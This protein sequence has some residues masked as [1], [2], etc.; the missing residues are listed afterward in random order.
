MSPNSCTAATPASPPTACWSCLARWIWIS[1]L[2]CAPA[3]STWRHMVCACASS[4]PVGHAARVLQSGARRGADA[5]LERSAPRPWWHRPHTRRPR[6]VRH[7]NARRANGPADYD[8]EDASYRGDPTGDRG[9]GETV[10]VAGDSHD[11]APGRWGGLDD[12]IDLA[13]RAVRQ[14]GTP[15]TRP[16]GAGSGPRGLGQT[17]GTP[18]PRSRAHR[19]GIS[20]YAPRQLARTPAALG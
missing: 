15:C 8:G 5:R 1:R 10:R 2:S 16:S 18:G 7:R 11:G 3:R 6:T 13:A 9:Y 19:Q 17:P 14:S 12:R 20:R 4:A